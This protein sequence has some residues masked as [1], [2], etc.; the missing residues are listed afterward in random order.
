VVPIHKNGE[1][2]DGS[3]YRGISLL[4]NLYK[5]LSVILLAKLTPYAEEIIEDNQ[6]G[7]RRNRST[8]DQIFISGKYWRKSGSLMIQFI[9]FRKA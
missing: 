5:I 2:T 4:S 7:F 9:D 8:T 1:K 6:C 3:N